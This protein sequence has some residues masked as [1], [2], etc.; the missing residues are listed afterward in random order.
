MKTKIIEWFLKGMGKANSLRSKVVIWFVKRETIK[1]AKEMKMSKSW[2]TTLFGCLGAVGVFLMNQKDPAW[3]S[4]VGQI[5]GA[6]GT[7]GIGMTARDNDKT[8][9]DVGAK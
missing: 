1:I 4:I 2:K 5:L 3:L 7:A 9:E 8:S 6:I